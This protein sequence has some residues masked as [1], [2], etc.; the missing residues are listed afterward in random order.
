MVE[1][2]NTIKAAI[3]GLPIRTVLRGPWMSAMVRSY[4]NMKNLRRT[5]GR[6]IVFPNFDAPLQRPHFGEHAL[7]PFIPGIAHHQARGLRAAGA[8]EFLRRFVHGSVRLWI[9][10]AADPD[11]TRPNCMP[12]SKP[13][14]R[15]L[16]L[17]MANLIGKQPYELPRCAPVGRVK[18]IGQ[19]NEK[20][21]AV[22]D[23]SRA[24]PD[25]SCGALCDLRPRLEE[26]RRGIVVPRIAS[27]PS[28]SANHQ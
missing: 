14:L 20:G 26:S 10:H 27:K 17:R 3:H 28:D 16:H 24:G 2:T 8:T 13:F 23:H 12:R 5:C 11:H 19:V 7:L 25:L 1:I 4:W 18:N 9:A 6:A 21:R 15:G 22:G